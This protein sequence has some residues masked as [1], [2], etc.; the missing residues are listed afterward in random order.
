MLSKVVD[1]E[2][3]GSVQKGDAIASLLLVGYPSTII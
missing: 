1:R 3:V 2:P